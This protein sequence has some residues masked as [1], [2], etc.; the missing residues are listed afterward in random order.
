MLTIAIQTSDSLKSPSNKMGNTQ[1]IETTM[2]QIAAECDV[3]VI[4]AGPAGA[5]AAKMLKMQGYNVTVLERN[6]FPRFSIGESLLPACM[7]LLEEADMLRD[8]EQAGFQ[9]K[10]GAT[11]RKGAQSY[12]FDF[13]NGF[14]Q[15]WGHTYQVQR[16]RFDDILAQNAA[17]AGVDILFGCTVEKLFL[18]K[19]NCALTYV[20]QYGERQTL[21][22]RFCLDASGMG[23]TLARALDLTLPSNFPVRQAVFAHFSI[24]ATKVSFEWDKITISI[25]PNKPDVWYWV[26]PFEDGTCSIGIVG[27]QH[28]FAEATKAKEDADEKACLQAGIEQNP[29]LKDLLLDAT[30]KGPV[31]Q[32]TGYAT[33]IK[34]LYGDGYAI[35]GNAGEFL[36][37]IFSSGVTI[38]LKS[39]SLAVAALTRQL[40]G[41]D[42]D[43]AT[44]FAAP[45]QSGVNVFRAYVDAWYDGTLP[46]VFFHPS[47][48]REIVRMLCSILAGYVWDDANPYVIHPKR[49]LKALIN[50]CQMS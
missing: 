20:N 38:A 33:N 1:N 36:D 3:A 25:H 40:R 26:I 27:K 8:V 10:N 6:L 24:P 43:W 22:S 47:P 23:Q 12:S 18:A 28:F 50:L 2:T 41:E 45:L 4:G 15:G 13:A 35:L 32:L 21:H 29:F 49:R 16:A 31:R 39:A 19:D 37:P 11:F 34:Q 9:L 7:N 48:S 30:V 42:V 14:S 17:C 44:S 5:S 46:Q